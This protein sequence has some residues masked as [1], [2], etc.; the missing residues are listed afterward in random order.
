MKRLS[1]YAAEVLSAIKG[2]ELDGREPLSLYAP[3]EYAMN[4]GGKRL[5]PSLT[6]MTAEAFGASAS[7]AMPA[8]LGLEMFHNF[9]LLHDDVMDKSDMRR[10]RQ[11]VHV[12]WDENTAILSGDTMLSLAEGLMMRVVD[13]KLRRVM[14]IFNRMSLEV[15]E[16]QAYDMSYEQRESISVEEYLEMVR[17]KTGSLLGA[18]AETGAV[19]GGASAESAMCMR[20]YGEM[21]GVAFQIEDDWLDT[22][23]NAEVFGKP[24]GGD[25]NNG[26][27]TYLLTSGLSAGGADSE[28][29]R[30]AVSLPAGELRVKAVTR[31]YDKMG[32][33]QLCRD[34]IARYSSRA[35]E[36]VKR[37]G[38]SES[39]VEPFKALLDKLTGRKS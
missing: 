32:L 25:I 17:L 6:L 38:L 8:A 23:G 4:A 29:L 24:I 18:C 7:E 39:A 14:E 31:I 3:I 12:K 34:A 11:T 30:A 21:L 22:Y 26:K 35:L 1:E 13:D 9:T 15:Y 37:S 27:K 19:I 33:S 20:E 36:A 2:L 10:G 28:A 16:G 5:R